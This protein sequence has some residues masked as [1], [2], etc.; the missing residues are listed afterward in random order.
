MLAALFASVPLCKECG[1]WLL[2]KCADKICIRSQN[3][4]PK[5][6]VCGLSGSRKIKKTSSVSLFFLFLWWFLLVKCCEGSVILLN[7]QAKMLACCSFT[8]AGR[9]CDILGSKV[10]GDLL[11]TEIVVAWYHHFSCAGSS[12]IQFP[13]AAWTGPGDTSTCIRLLIGPEK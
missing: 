12:K 9:R 10:K 3:I 6:S 1:S 8:V 4:Y 5:V 13:W 7:L 2:Y 11:L